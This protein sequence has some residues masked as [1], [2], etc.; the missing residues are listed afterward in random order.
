MSEPSPRPWHRDHTYY[1]TDLNRRDVANTYFSYHQHDVDKANARLI[2][3]A[4]NAYD[5]LMGAC[6]AVE[7]LLDQGLALGMSVED[8]KVS[9]DILHTE[10]KKA[11][12]ED[13]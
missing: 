8:V 3:R 6:K 7:A 12:A 2:V 11:E 4:V 1:I 5:S 10:I 13:E 9:Y